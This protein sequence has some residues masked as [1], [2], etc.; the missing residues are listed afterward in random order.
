MSG[1]D[2]S[3]GF[4]GGIQLD[5]DGLILEQVATLRIEFATP[6]A[7]TQLAAL[8]FEGTGGDANFFPV[9][10]D[11]LGAV[12]AVELPITHFSG[13]A[14]VGASS[15]EVASTPWPPTPLDARYMHRLADII[16]TGVEQGLV[17]VDFNSNTDAATSVTSGMR[18]WLGGIEG[19]ASPSF[20]T[21]ADINETFRSLNSRSIQDQLFGTGLDSS[22]DPD[23]QTA[24]SN[25]QTAI[26]PTYGILNER[27]TQAADYCA[28]H[29]D[30]PCG[31]FIERNDALNCQ[32]LSD[33]LVQR[34]GLPD[35]PNNILDLCPGSPDKMI[36]QR[37]DLASN[38]PFEVCPM[39]ASFTVTA[40]V[41]DQTGLPI[42]I[43]DP[44]AWST[45][46][47]SVLGVSA[48]GNVATV[49]PA[50]GLGPAVL[51]AK[52]TTCLEF[53]ASANAF[54]GVAPSLVGSWTASGT[55]FQTGC[56]D[57]EEDFP[58]TFVSLDGEI[59]AQITN[60]N[61]TVA[62]NLFG[63]GWGGVAT[64]ECGGPGAT[65]A[66]S[67]AYFFEGGYGI[68][69]YGGTMTSQIGPP[70][71]RVATGFSWTWEANDVDGDTCHAG[72]AGTLTR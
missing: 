22:S 65:F 13:F 24:W 36:F 46:S 32:I 45:S 41:Q 39:D 72:G 44:I 52:W 54:V 31:K 66:G 5:P 63:P 19:R 43:S 23:D 1:F 10:L 26:T 30:D 57:P 64:L 7:A 4:L 15:D 70:G 2:G 51:S 60:P 61:G 67:E 33:L 8:A 42:S 28:S 6:P 59:E 58:P 48:V 14:A 56:Q 27:Y 18:D 9:A 3:G 12:S 16:Q 20:D 17:G 11:T 37:Q 35:T 49:T 62:F 21:C 68:D 53:P 34:F 69:T 47:S 38:A 50:G 71:Q 25:M 29:E 55:I 40:T